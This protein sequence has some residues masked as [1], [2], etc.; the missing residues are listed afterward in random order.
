MKVYIL[1]DLEGAAG[2]VDFQTQTYETAPGLE[3]ARRLATLELNALIDGCLDAG[4]QEIVVLDGHGCGGLTYELLHER[5]RLIMGRPITAPYGLDESFDAMM[6]CGH[7][8]MNHTPTGVLCHSWNSRGIDE[9]RLNGELIGEI[10]FNCAMA[11]HF[12][13]PMILVSGDV[14]TA[15]ET[16]RYV[17]NV[18]AVITKEGLSRTSAVCI[19]PQASQKLHREGGRRALERL[20]EFRPVIIDPPYEFTTR[21]SEQVDTSSLRERPDLAEV[22]EATFAIRSDNIVDI[23]SRR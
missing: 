13:V 5:A 6:L 11:G 8:A 23:A 9:C 20:G 3:G 21:Y 15:E 22:G 17:P 4:A 18:E 16:R 2:V 19:A 12:G 1:C 10:G 14:A 7:H